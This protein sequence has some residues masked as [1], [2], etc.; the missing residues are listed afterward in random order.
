[1]K[2]IDFFP[3][4]SFGSIFGGQVG[5]GFKAYSPKGFSQLN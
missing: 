3:Y 5:C 2:V 4:T 1:M